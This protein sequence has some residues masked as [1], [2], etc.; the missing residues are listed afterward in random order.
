[1]VRNRWK[2]L[3]WL[4]QNSGKIENKNKTEQLSEI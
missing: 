4:L 1:M 2:H 3:L